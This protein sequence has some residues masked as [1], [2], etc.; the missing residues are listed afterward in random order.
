MYVS[1]YIQ[2]CF[3]SVALACCT[4]EKTSSPTV[5]AD[6]PENR[7]HAA[8]EYL[9]VVPP[10]DLMKDTAAKVGETMPESV[11]AT[12]LSPWIYRRTG[13]GISTTRVPA[14]A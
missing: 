5:V 14:S 12:T 9:R 7:R 3:L 2:L 11:R 6:T 8:E 4:S 10:A 1:R 13:R